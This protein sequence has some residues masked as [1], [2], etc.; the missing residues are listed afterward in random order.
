MLGLYGTTYSKSTKRAGSKQI[1]SSIA[2]SFN[3]D[4]VKIIPDVNIYHEN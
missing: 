3:E 4:Y 2:C 1:L